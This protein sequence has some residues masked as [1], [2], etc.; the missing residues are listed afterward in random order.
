MINE[1]KQLVYKNYTTDPNFVNFMQS[2]I[3]D[4]LNNLYDLQNTI[5]L[6]SLSMS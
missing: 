6:S 2:D 5:S 4:S 1:K 3:E